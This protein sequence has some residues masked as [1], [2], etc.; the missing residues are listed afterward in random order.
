VSKRNSFSPSKAA[1]AALGTNGF[2]A[3]TRAL[4]ESDAWEGRSIHL[5][6]VINRLELEH[7]DHAGKQNG[8]LKVTYEDFVKH[9]VSR[10][11]IKPALQEGVARGLLRI[12]HKGR[13]MGDGRHDPSLYRLTYLASKYIPV[14]GAPSYLDPTN[15]WKQF[16]GKPERERRPFV[17]GAASKGGN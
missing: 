8:Y 11:F 1:K 13:Y 14:A 4:L 5:V 7:L 17:W 16:S 6:R 3:H 10:R 12:E 9:R 15:E 2:I